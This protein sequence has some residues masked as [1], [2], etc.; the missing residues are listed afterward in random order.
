MILFCKLQP[1]LSHALDVG[2]KGGRGREEGGGRAPHS[3]RL[4]AGKKGVTQGEAAW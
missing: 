4:D 3:H 1:L 2:G